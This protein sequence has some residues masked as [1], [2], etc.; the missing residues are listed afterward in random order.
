MFNEDGTVVNTEG[1][2][3]RYEVDGLEIVVF[4]DG[5]RDSGLRLIDEFT[6]E[7]PETGALFIREGGEGYGGL[8]GLPAGPRVFFTGEYYFLDGEPHSETSFLFQD[9]G[10]AIIYTPDGIESGTYTLAGNELSISVGGEVRT[11]LL[12]LDPATLESPLSGEVFGLAGLFD[13]E[14]VLNERYYQFGDADDVCLYFREG[15]WEDGD[16]EDG[17]DEDGD[18]EEGKADS[19]GEVVFEFLGEEIAVGSYAVYGHLLVIEL[20]DESTEM[21]ILNYYVLGVARQ[22]VLFIRL[23][24]S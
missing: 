15:E 3:G 5:E 23:P 18:D 11:V 6:M 21:M 20:D 1:F 22:D 14:L 24:P 19:R 13:L 12:I 9:D 2:E 16:D 17:D 4:V 10:I 7:D 8:S